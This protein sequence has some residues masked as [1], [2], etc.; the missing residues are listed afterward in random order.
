MLHSECFFFKLWTSKKIIIIDIHAIY[1]EFNELVQ[2]IA[3]NGEVYSYQ[4]LDY[5]R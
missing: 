1:F 2:K 3:Q 5:L 4:N